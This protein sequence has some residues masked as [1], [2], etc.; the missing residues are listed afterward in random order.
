MDIRIEGTSIV[1]KTYQKPLNLYLYLPYSSNHN[2][3][4]F[5]GVIYG[6]M[7]KYR[8][9][10]THYSDYLRFTKLLYVRHLERGH[11]AATLKPLFLDAHA[12]IK[13][14]RTEPPPPPPEEREE[15][16]LHASYLHWEYHMD[17]LPSKTIRSSYDKN[18]N[19]FEEAL[20]VSA[21]KICYHRPKNIG[22]MATQARL[23]QADG[24]PASHYMGEFQRGLNP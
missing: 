14:Q 12:K 24:L 11:Q 15:D 6:L 3:K 20:G 10:N 22:D 18:C 13:Q 8:E 5:K 21:P 17:D 16:P 9:Q 23:H 19:T 7:K 2:R 1:T 4:L